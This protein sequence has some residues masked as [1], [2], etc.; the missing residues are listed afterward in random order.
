MSAD[1]E[2]VTISRE[3]ATGLVGLLATLEGHVRVGDVSPNAAEHLQ[4]RL[5]RDLGA[6]SSTPLEHMLW[7]PNEKLRRSLGEP[8]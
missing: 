2:M 3:D 4:R 8:G 1:E 7:S 6:D 5:V